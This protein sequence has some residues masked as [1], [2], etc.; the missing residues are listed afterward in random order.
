[1]ETTCGK[2]ITPLAYRIG[3][4]N[5]I[6]AQYSADS[7]LHVRMDAQK[8]VHNEEIVLWYREKQHLRESVGEY[9][10]G[11]CISIHNSQHH[12]IGSHGTQ[13]HTR[14][15]NHLPSSIYL[16]DTSSAS[17][18][19]LTSDIMDPFKTPL[20][21]AEWSFARLCWRVLIRFV[22]RI[23]RNAA[24][25]DVADDVVVDDDDRVWVVC[26]VSNCWASRVFHDCARFCTHYWLHS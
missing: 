20:I 3:L 17:S 9:S 2:R 8:Y 23:V 7:Q 6:V 22:L 10:V 5:C 11:L 21:L 26:G 16:L 18:S 25:D 14:S 24:D 12:H 15:K 13:T 4:A 19:M 1:M